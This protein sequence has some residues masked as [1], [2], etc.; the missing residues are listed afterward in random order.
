MIK[1]KRWEWVLIVGLMVTSFYIP[2]SIAGPLFG[3]PKKQRISRCAE[4]Y[5]YIPNVVGTGCQG[6]LDP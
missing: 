2:S 4:H 1:S 6:Y 5:V 3:S